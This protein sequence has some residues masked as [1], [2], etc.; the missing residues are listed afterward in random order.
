MCAAFLT[1][2]LR[3][4]HPVWSHCAFRNQ[5]ATKWVVPA[6]VNLAVIHSALGAL[7]VQVTIVGVLQYR[8]IMETCAVVGV[9]DGTGTIECKLWLE[10]R[11]DV[12]HKPACI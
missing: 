7:R 8:N 6:A 5:T 12:R 1:P 2:Q 3:A 9:F 11:R 10:E 4:S